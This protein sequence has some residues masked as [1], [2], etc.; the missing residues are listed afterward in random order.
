LLAADAIHCIRSAAGALDL[1]AIVVDGRTNR[2]RASVALSDWNSLRVS[3][4]FCSCRRPG[5]VGEQFPT[6]KVMGM[7]ETRR[8]KWKG[9]N[10][11][12]DAINP[13]ANSPAPHLDSRRHIERGSLE[14]RRCPVP[15]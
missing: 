5:G 4:C 14:P 8:T 7:G 2:P 6:M 12:V 15:A 10:G 11:E 3:D 1:F 9:G 13:A